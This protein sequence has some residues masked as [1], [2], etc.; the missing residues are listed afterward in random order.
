MKTLALMVVMTAT[1]C[2]AFERVADPVDDVADTRGDAVVADSS[3]PETSSDSAVVDTRD[4]AECSP[5]VVDTPIACGTKCRTQTRTC[6]TDGRWGAYGACGAEGPCAPGDVTTVA[7]AC[8]AVGDVQRETCTASCAWGA[9]VCVTPSGWRPMSA[10]PL[11]GRVGH[12]AVWTGSEMLDWGGQN[13]DGTTYY[14]DG[15]RYK[16]ASDSWTMMAAPPAGIAPRTGHAVVWT[17]SKLIVWGGNGTA[18]KLAD[19]A[20]YDPTANTWTTLPSSTLTGRQPAAVF[21]TTTNEILVW[22]SAYETPLG[23]GSIYRPSLRDLWVSFPTAPL[24]ARGFVAYAWAGV[25]FMVW[26]GADGTTIFNDGA[27]YN[28]VTGTWKALDAPPLGYVSRIWFGQGAV[29]GGLFIVGGVNS[30]LSPL[31]DGLYFDASG[32]SQLVGAIPD[33][34]LSSPQR[35]FFQTWCDNTDRC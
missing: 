4:A 5:G 24:L 21:S 14:A 10:S 20:A 11:A 34:V 15:A 33:A 2:S 17:G 8:A 30:S 31:S 3:A 1:G 25:Q 19:G 16:L 22:G 29:N 27:R 26:G 28:P 6:G 13:V 18:G 7:G 9:P 32:A 12:R 35:M 23:D